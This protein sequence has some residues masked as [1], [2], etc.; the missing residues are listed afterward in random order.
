MWISYRLARVCGG[1]FS[2]ALLSFRFLVL[3]R[4]RSEELRIRAS[5]YRQNDN[6]SYSGVR[7]F[8]SGFKESATSSA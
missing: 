8:Y 5:G 6:L 4:N 7:T 2:N 1:D 3:R